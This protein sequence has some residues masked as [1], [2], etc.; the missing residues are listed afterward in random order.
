MN[1]KDTLMRFTLAAKAIL[2]EPKRMAQ[3]MGMMATKTGAVNAV[4]TVISA[5]EQK[6]PVPPEVAPLLGVTILMLVVDMAKQV[7][8]KA[9]APELLNEVVSELMQ[10]VNDAH[11]QP[12]QP[13]QPEAQPAQPP[14]GI[15][16]GATA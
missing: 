6:Q 12:S 3:I 1:Y 9:P 2:Y 14:Q 8:G 10:N 13:A 5:I 11:Q 15:I 4:H 16:Q 7:T